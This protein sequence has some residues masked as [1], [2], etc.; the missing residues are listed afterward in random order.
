VTSS[1]KTE[2]A[3]YGCDTEDEN[4]NTLAAVTSGVAEKSEEAAF[5]D[6]TDDEKTR[7]ESHWVYCRSLLALA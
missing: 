1:V 2:D 5:N 4:D 3:A 7:Q 6:D